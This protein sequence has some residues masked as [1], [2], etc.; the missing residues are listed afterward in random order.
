ASK[1]HNIAYIKKIQVSKPSRYRHC[2][3]DPETIAHI[4]NHCP[5]NLDS[6]IKARH[7]KALERITT[8]IKN[9]VA[10]RG[11]TLKIDSCPEDM[12]TL[13][14]PDII[15]RDDKRKKMTIADVAVVFEDYKKNSFGAARI[16]KEEKYQS[17]KTHYEK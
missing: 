6:K 12:E 13:L 17:L 11:K 2:T 10:N 14:R 4:L 9:S 16:N 7:D 5:H 8:A 1:L 15:L 3:A